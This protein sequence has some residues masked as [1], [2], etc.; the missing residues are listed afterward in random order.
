MTNGSPHPPRYRAA[1]RLLEGSERLAAIFRRE[2]TEFLRRGLVR[3]PELDGVVEPF[4]RKLGEELIAVRPNPAAPWARAGGILRLSLHDGEDRLATEIA[5]L[6]QLLRE[7]VEP[8]EGESDD[9]EALDFV[10]AAL[11][12]LHEGVLDERARLEGRPPRFAAPRFGGVATLVFSEPSR[13]VAP[14]VP[15]E[16]S[17]EPASP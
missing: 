7:V 2:R 9:E 17:A 14:H 12:V 11:D 4:L 8:L 16:T 13:A 6:R 15:R 3:S 5:F 1:R 10:N